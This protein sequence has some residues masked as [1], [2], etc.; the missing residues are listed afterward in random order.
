[1][2][3]ALALFAYGLLKHCHVPNAPS[4]RDIKIMRAV[5]M[6]GSRQGVKVSGR[7]APMHSGQPWRAIAVS[8]RPR[9]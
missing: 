7:V 9:T 3:A 1:M 2:R 4:P 5:C 6:M 8:V